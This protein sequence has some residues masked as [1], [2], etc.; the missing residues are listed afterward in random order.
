MWLSNCLNLLMCDCTS[1]KTGLQKNNMIFE[2]QLDSLAY[3]WV[4]KT[5][6]NFRD[7]EFDFLQAERNKQWDKISPWVIDELLSAWECVHQRKLKYW[8]STVR[9]LSTS[10]PIRGSSKQQSSHCKAALRNRAEQSPLHC[11]LSQVGLLT[12][13]THTHRHT[14]KSLQSFSSDSEYR[15]TLYYLLQPRKYHI[16]YLVLM[17]MEGRCKASSRAE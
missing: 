2:V 14:L 6:W 1:R 17:L 4:W 8:L 16:M 10:H 15:I 3:V 11:T 9:P 5:R 12:Q 7:G 13:N